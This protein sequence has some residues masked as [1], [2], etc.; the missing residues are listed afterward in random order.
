MKISDHLKNTAF[1]LVLCSRVSVSL[2]IINDLQGYLS[3]QLIVFLVIKHSLVSV[4]LE[5]ILSF[6]R[7]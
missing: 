1:D 6:L 7:F 2:K 4:Y 5:P 3:V